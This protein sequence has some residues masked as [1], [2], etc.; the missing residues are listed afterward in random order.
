MNILFFSTCMPS[1]AN[2]GLRNSLNTS[3]KAIYSQHNCSLI[4][5]YD[6]ESEIEATKRE[7]PNLNIIDAYK[8]KASNY[9]R[10]KAILCGKAPA[11]MANFQRKIKNKLYEVIKNGN[12]DLIFFYTLGSFYYLP[13]NCNLPTILSVNDSFSMAL[14]RNRQKGLKKLY[15]EISRKSIL[16]IEKKGYKKFSC[17]HVVS[18]IDKNILLKGC[19]DLSVRDIPIAAPNRFFEDRIS[20]DKIR[21]LYCENNASPYPLYGIVE[22]LDNSYSFLNSSVDITLIHKQNSRQLDEVCKKYSNIK[23]VD[24]IDDFSAELRRTDIFIALDTIGSGLKNR[25]LQAMAAG[26]C[27]VATPVAME[28]FC[29]E[30]GVHAF[31]ESNI[32]N[33]SERIKA[34]INNE[35]QIK[36]ISGNARENAKEHYSFDIVKRKWLETVQ[37]IVK[38]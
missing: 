6:N 7:F 31:C 28:G 17:I 24:F 33:I 8:F 18:P 29:Y 13:S 32:Q 14:S 36:I 22:F 23:N 16:Q 38:N 10:I 26:C 4:G 30:N 19:P 21:L 15:N 34:L 9:N 20:H 5:M 3:L 12:F 27:V 37:T 35:N 11:A 2:N 25:V 1:P